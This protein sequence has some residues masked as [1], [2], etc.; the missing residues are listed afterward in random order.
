M[1][2]NQTKLSDFF[3]L[4]TESA[5]QSAPKPSNPQDEYKEF[6]LVLPFT[7]HLWGVTPKISDLRLRAHDANNYAKYE[8]DELWGFKHGLTIHRLLIEG[9][10]GEI[11][12]VEQLSGNTFGNGSW[13]LLSTKYCRNIAHIVDYING[14][15]LP[16][17]DLEL[18]SFLEQN[19]W[20]TKEEIE[21]M[22]INETQF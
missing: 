21:K 14:E 13:L 7:T 20:A 3:I 11:F 10:S 2:H 4:A 15:Q 1:E 6:P 16:L 5:P 18:F 8:T 22:K 12:S 19:K 17:T 9:K